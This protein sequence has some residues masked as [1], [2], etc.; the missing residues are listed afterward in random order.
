MVKMTKRTAIALGVGGWV[1]A[2]CSAV[3]LTYDLSRPLR[4]R[5]AAQVMQ[6][7][8]PGAQPASPER[9][10]V[11]HIPAITIVGEKLPSSAAGLP[12]GPE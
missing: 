4:I 11:L 5:A 10:S 9:D 3:A 6:L 1:V 2:L 8:P 12:H 7:V